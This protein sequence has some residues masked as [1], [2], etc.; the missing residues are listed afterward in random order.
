MR[1]T[2]R[3][4]IGSAGILACLCLKLD[5]CLNRIRKTINH[6]F[7]SHRVQYLL[8]L[9]S[10]PLARTFCFNRRASRGAC[11]FG[12]VVEIDVQILSART[13]CSIHLLQAPQ[14]RLR[15]TASILLLRP[16]ES[17]ICDWPDGQSRDVQPGMS[18]AQKEAPRSSNS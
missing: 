4:G 16:V 15:I 12:V 1:I 11:A 18:C 5:Y 9:T 17:D 6:P 14:R 10:K 3:A 2:D 13:C 8:V 7:S